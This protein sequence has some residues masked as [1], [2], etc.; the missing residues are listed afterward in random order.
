MRAIRL[1]LISFIMLA[2][3]AGCGRENPSA[4]GGA[5]ATRLPAKPPVVVT[6]ST[7]GPD[8]IVV[9]PGNPA[10]LMYADGRTFYMAGPGDPE[11]FLYR[12]TR[13]ADGT[14]TG[15][16]LLL[17]DKLAQWGGNCIYL[18]AVRSDGGDGGPTENPFIDSDKSNALDPDILD[19]W[20]T[21]FQAMDAAGIVVY[22]FLYDDS[23]CL[24]ECD[25]ATDSIPPLQEVNFIAGI[26]NRF[27]HLEN[28]IWVLA[29]EYAEAFSAERISY[30]AS[31]VRG[32]DDF[33]HVVAVHKQT[34]ID[35]SE[36]ANDPN[37]DQFAVQ[38]PESTPAEVYTLM[39][40]AH[41]LA[42]GD[43]NLNMSESAMHGDGANARRKNW[44]SAMAGAYV[45]VLGW[46]IATT[47]A[48][49]LADCRVL[50]DFMEQ[51]NYASMTPR[52]DLA[53]GDTEYCLSNGADEYVLYA[54]NRAGELGAKG[55]TPG[56]YDFHWLDI[57]TGTTIFQAGVAAS[58]ADETFPAPPGIGS[59]AAAHVAPLS[60]TGVP[61]GRSDSY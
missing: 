38:I 6:Q 60:Y 16:Q 50:I 61:Y 37:I 7:A 15:D 21:W 45:M 57:A 11:G 17:I 29:E 54:S 39:E 42:D 30:M 47:S 10:Y 20:E 8:Q 25:T 58:G 46:D 44:A 41:M 4:P 18:Q 1:V 56:L 48:S 2:S 31:I 22:F 52:N 19:Q 36:F 35:F 27:E 51:T 14:R 3:G 24:W 40:N 33:D 5:D 32:A 53:F 9:D 55:I 13:N 28:I 49:D 43:Y 23:A 34:G 26:V 12:G 59:E